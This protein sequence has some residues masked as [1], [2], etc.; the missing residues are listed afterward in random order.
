MT[1]RFTHSATEFKTPSNLC[2]HIQSN[3]LRDSTK[4]ATV[5]SLVDNL[6]YKTSQQTMQNA[7]RTTN[8]MMATR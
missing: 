5:P 7:N 4:F 6:I 3:L 1:I 2:T 8:Y